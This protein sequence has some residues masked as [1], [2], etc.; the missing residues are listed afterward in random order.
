MVCVFLWPLVGARCWSPL[1]KTPERVKQRS[2]SG[3]KDLGFC[4]LSPL[5]SK[6]FP[7][8]INFLGESL[9]LK[10]IYDLLSKKYFR[11]LKH[12]GYF[13]CSLTEYISDLQ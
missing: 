7:K 2:A 4:H 8:E 13:Y 9:E 10:F 1:A 3:K 11:T 5:G 6:K 12:I